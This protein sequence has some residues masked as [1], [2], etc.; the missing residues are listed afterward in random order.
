MPPKPKTSPKE[1][2]THLL[3]IVTLYISAGSFITL[4]FQLI[5]ILFP[6][7]LNFY[8]N[9]GGPLRWALSSLLI[10][11]P[12]YLWASRF[13]Y[14]DIQKNPA[15]AEIK[16]RKWLVYFTLFAAAGFI[17]GDLVTLVYNFLEGDLTLRFILKIAAVL[18]VAGAI[19]GYYLGDLRRKSVRM[20]TGAKV[21]SWSVIALVLVSLVCGFWL[22]GSPFKQRAIRF[23]NERVGHLQTIQGQ[24]VNY[25]IQK[26]RL[27]N[28]LDDLVDTISGFRPSVD[29]ETGIA[30]EYKVSG[31][32]DFELCASFNL[33]SSAAQVSVRKAI[34]AIPYPVAEG[35]R[36]ENWEHG[37]GY[38]CFQRK[39]DPEL[40]KPTPVK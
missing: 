16:I 5:N 1:V 4:L 30:Y 21:F 2:F 26:S 36:E 10:I 22:A 23:D 17:I 39:I 35:F 19:F 11:F 6:D 24:T 13:I 34:P 8:Y 7:P 40:Y 14:R 20:T 27:P 29:P 28:T 18:L 38:Q 31:K 25:W 12:V 37:S 15:N 33:P 32:L 9:P 3:A